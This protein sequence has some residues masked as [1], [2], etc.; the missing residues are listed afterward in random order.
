MRKINKMMKRGVALMLALYMIFTMCGIS[1]DI[2]GELFGAITAAAETEFDES[3]EADSTTVL[4]NHWRLRKASSD[5]S[6]TFEEVADEYRFYPVKDADENITSVELY[7][8][9]D[10]SFILL[11][12]YDVSGE[13]YSNVAFVVNPQIDDLND[14]IGEEFSNFS[15]SS[16]H[17]CVQAYKYDPDDTAGFETTDGIY[18]AV[19]AEDLGL[20]KFPENYARLVIT[21]DPSV[22][23][24]K[25]HAFYISDVAKLHGV[26]FST[27]GEFLDDEET[28]TNPWWDPDET[29]IDDNGEEKKGKVVPKPE[30]DTCFDEKT[31]TMYYNT[32]SGLHTNKTAT[33]VNSNI[34][35]DGRT[36]DL[37]L[38][39]W[40]SGENLADVGLILDASGSMAWTTNTIAPLEID[41]RTV[42]KLGGKSALGRVLTAKEVDQVLNKANTDNTL[43]S[44]AG[45]NYYVYDSRSQQ[46]EFVPIAYWG[47]NTAN[48]PLV[49]TDEIVIDKI[50]GHYSF[51]NS[52]LNLETGNT[53]ATLIEHA[54]ESGFS[55]KAL[56]DEKKPKYYNS[57][58]GVNL[59]ETDKAGSIWLDVDTEK[60]DTGNF[61]VSF[62]LLSESASGG[63]NCETPIIYIGDKSMTSFYEFARGNS[64]DSGKSNSTRL[65][66]N[67]SAANA[68]AG[69]GRVFQSDD[70]TLS[71]DGKTWDKFTIVVDNDTVTF[72]KGTNIQNNKDPKELIDKMAITSPI[73]NIDDLVIL[74]GGGEL[75]DNINGLQPNGPSKN[76]IRNVCIVNRGINASEVSSLSASTEGV[77]GYFPL[78]GTLENKAAGGRSARY[79]ANAE[80]SIDTDNILQGE[81]SS[82]VYFDKGMS[83][84]ALDITETAKLG[85][86]ELDVKPSD[87]NYT[88]S[89]AVRKNG[90]SNAIN[91]KIAYGNFMYIGDYKKTNFYEIYRRNAGYLEL[92]HSNATEGSDGGT[93]SDGNHLFFQGGFPG[94]DQWHVIT[95]TVKDNKNGTVTITPYID[96]QPGDGG[97]FPNGTNSDGT[98]KTGAGYVPTAMPVTAEDPSIILAGL[99]DQTYASLYPNTK[100]YLDELYVI[101]ETLSADKVEDLYSIVKADAYTGGKIAYDNAG[102]PIAGELDAKLTGAPKKDRTGWFYMN[103]HSVWDSITSESVGTGK[104]LVGLHKEELWG[105]NTKN[106]N[107]ANTPNSYKTS[108]DND[109]NK[110]VAEFIAA[111]K[112]YVPE[113]SYAKDTY[114]SIPFYLVKAPAMKLCEEEDGVRHLERDET[115]EYAYYL[116]CYFRASDNDTES[117]TAVSEANTQCSYVYYKPDNERVKRESLQFALGKFTSQLHAESP[118]SRISAVRFSARGAQD[119]LDQL[120]VMD[121]TKD[122]RSSGIISARRGSGS[123][124][125]YDSTPNDSYVNNRDE[126]GSKDLQPVI[127]Q[128]NYALTG[129]TYTWTGLKAFYENLVYNNGVSDSNDKDNDGIVDGGKKSVRRDTRYDANKNPYVPQAKRYAIIFTDGKD[130]TVNPT[131]NNAYEGGYYYTGGEEAKKWA[132]TLKD[133][134]YTIYCVMFAGG[135][136]SETFNPESFYSSKNYLKDLATDAGHVHVATNNDNL[137]VAFDEILAEI[138]AE[139]YGFTIQDYIDP[140]F[141]LIDFD[142][143]GNEKC[144]VYLGPGGVISYTENRRT[145]TKTKTLSETDYYVYTPDFTSDASQARLFYDSGKDMYYIKWVG[146]PDSSGKVRDIEIPSCAVGANLL[147]AWSST[148]R[149]T[150]KN[151]FVGGNSIL[152]N[153]NSAGMNYV[154][155]PGEPVGVSSGTDKADPGVDENYDLNYN[156][157][158]GFPRVAVNV[159]LLPIITKDIPNVSYMGEGIAP[160]QLLTDIE[161]EYITDSYYLEYLKR[162]AYQRYLNYKEM[163][164][165]TEE[166]AEL[167]R[168]KA[169]MNLP[170]FRLL[171]KWLKIG[172]ENE[173]VKS[174]SIPYIY[175]P[176]VEYYT[177]GANEGQIITDA[178]GNASIIKNNAGQ[179]ESNQKDVVG[180]MTYRWERI[181]S[182]AN[183]GD[184]SPTENYVVDNTERIRYSIT[185]EFT[186][187]RNGDTADTFKEINESFFADFLNINV[188]NSDNE[189]KTSFDEF[190]RE[191]YNNEYLIDE[192]DSSENAVYKWDKNYKPAVDE[193]DADP[194]KDV[195]IDDV[196]PRNILDEDTMQPIYSY[197]TAK[198][199]NPEFV[200]GNYDRSESYKYR[201]ISAQA[202]YTKDFVSGAIAL[203][204][205]IPVKEL[206]EACSDDGSYRGKLTAEMTREFTDNA[207]IESVK[208]GDGMEDYVGPFTLGFQ[209]DYS[210]DEVEELTNGQDDY[211]YVAVFAPATEVKAYWRTVTYEYDPENP[212]TRVKHVENKDLTIDPNEL[213]IGTYTV[214]L[215]SIKQYD[216]E[217]TLLTK[218]DSGIMKTALDD[219][220]EADPYIPFDFMTA[221]NDIVKYR[222]TRPAQEGGETVDKLLFGNQI[223]NGLNT[224]NE[225]GGET[226]RKD[227]AGNEIAEPEINAENIGNY[228]ANSSSLG[229]SQLTFNLGTGADDR[230][231]NSTFGT[232]GAKPAN[233]YIDDRLGIILLSIGS[234]D[235]TVRK[236][237]GGTSRDEVLDHIWEFK[238]SLKPESEE[239]IAAV[240]AGFV[241]ELTNIFSEDGKINGYLDEDTGEII[242]GTTEEPARIMFDGPD[243]D[244]IY[245]AKI[246]LKNGYSLKLKEL[247]VGIAYS[248][249]ETLV[250]GLGIY[251]VETTGPTSGTMRPEVEVD[252]MNNFIELEFP[253][254]GNGGNLW[255][256]ALIGG[257]LLITLL[258]VLYV[259]FEN[260][261]QGHAG[262]H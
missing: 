2:V 56:T 184:H 249:T 99:W 54:A 78:T 250:P 141:D 129:G 48:E 81:A 21:Y 9:H 136:V 128:Y 150:A 106:I 7:R 194:E 90:D 125:G 119:H 75:L 17:S 27:A 11:H 79:I 88:I 100:L 74:V 45:Y 10:N 49:E 219:G 36:Y 147:A 161:N 152:T 67:N 76:H 186:P 182:G 80:G 5:S 153:G 130:N 114:S 243:A 103:S 70:G 4:I 58:A 179:S 22:H 118:R 231:G 239:E 229:K 205:W 162:Y 252:F 215:D 146:L 18:G 101:D 62:E 246:Y 235:L 43:L 223:L 197:G 201:T 66:F 257:M 166:Q 256:T 131:K 170:L 213:P 185:V 242:E 190:D 126:K 254:T 233:Y 188:V 260:D 124:A 52:L 133:A 105:D 247:P 20:E 144:R 40:F 38:E 187:L 113:F 181:E 183:G 83:G 193:Y 1:P 59:Q 86:I 16:G 220:E 226:W 156:P 89:F 248:V 120:V 224:T 171:D 237:V 198:F 34:G 35:L 19:S 155:K 173:P 96:G 47:G 216:S 122:S 176:S 92:R 102:N 110:D 255:Y 202:T 6:V 160:A 68:G 69:N 196:Q 169:E 71:A 232:N 225:V 199:I 221:E 42:D 230:R 139:L 127:N 138:D 63:D 165:A 163:A 177:S 151:D 93:H 109:F 191:V 134:G 115:R 228:I 61:T 206:K 158:K 189:L 180:I 174:F 91:G 29:W 203:E 211:K 41:A 244:G 168:L 262:G 55:G 208:K 104:Q 217:G 14:K 72:Y 24:I 123:S 200:P 30:I 175:L 85:A 23:L 195:Y 39:S 32:S 214:K 97:K 111:S 8:K 236:Y 143:N 145:V 157:S 149:V 253:E 140:R 240:E 148:V 241:A 112:A 116:C 132:K 238:I 222:T 3:M 207:S 137:A 25:G 33:A 51:E 108:K 94:N 251:E 65:R 164:D 117:G 87:Y 167:A 60:F 259:A 26:D 44:Y 37:K 53:G 13:D 172:D 227:E 46:A 212:G 154:F 107:G 98:P 95:Y 28:V 218:D 82:P 15:V 73:A 261:K 50:I 64:N 57:N 209:F 31:G 142:G 234:A 204:L 245:T 77:I 178:D 258:L 192:V 84:R 12:T 121:W 135:S 210:A 159:R